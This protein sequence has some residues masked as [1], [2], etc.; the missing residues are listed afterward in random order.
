MADNVAFPLRE[1]RS[2]RGEEVDLLVAR[3]LAQVGLPQEAGGLLPAEL[4]GGMI[5]RVALARALALEPE[6]LLLDE[7]TAGLDPV[8]SEQ[9][10]R[11]IRELRQALGLTVVLVTHDLDTMRDLCDRI[12]VL[13]DRGVAALGSLDEVIA[14]EH[15]FVRDYFLGTRGARRVV[16]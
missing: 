7:P 11:L 13:A 12:A 9:F 10:V 3:K 16:A 2:F 4:S 6:L 8:A 5:K 1:M 14:V 15:P